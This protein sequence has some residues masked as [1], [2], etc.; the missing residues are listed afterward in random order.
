M[1]NYR[2]ARTP[3]YIFV[4]QILSVSFM[5]VFVTGITWWIIRLIVLSLKLHDAPDFSFIISIVIIPIFFTLASV[6]TYVFVGLQRHQAEDKDNKE[7]KN[8]ADDEM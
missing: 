2:D 3:P 4:L 5:W 6:L 8:E 1:L 7:G